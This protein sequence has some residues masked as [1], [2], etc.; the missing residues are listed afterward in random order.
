MQYMICDTSPRIQIFMRQLNYSTSVSHCS[1]ILHN[2]RNP[3]RFL[4]RLI[5]SI[6][7][8]EI[9]LMMKNDFVDEKSLCDKSDFIEKS[10]FVEKK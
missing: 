5:D 9:T 1:G 7:V 3:L 10:C 4:T 2:V 8:K 6:P